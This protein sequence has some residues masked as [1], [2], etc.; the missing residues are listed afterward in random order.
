MAS[1]LDSLS[2]NLVGVNGVMS[3]LSEEVTRNLSTLM[4]T[5]LLME[6]VGSV[7]VQVIAS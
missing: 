4:R 6:C 7:E 1:S 3:K 5:T 2:K